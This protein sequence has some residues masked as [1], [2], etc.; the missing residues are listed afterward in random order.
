MTIKTVTLTLLLALSACSN[1]HDYQ[2]PTDSDQWKQDEKFKASIKKLPDEEKKLLTAYLLRA[3]MAEAFG[4]TPPE[5]TIGDAIQNQKDFIEK[6]ALEAEAEKEE[7]TKQAALAAAVEQEH[8]KA[9]A[10]ARAALTVAVVSMEFVPSDAH[11]G[12]YEDGFAITMALQNNTE[13]YMAGV[14][15]AVVFADMFGDNIKSVNLSLDET[16]AAGS[17]LRWSGSLGYN[18][19]KDDDKKLRNTELAKMKISWEPEV[20]LFSDGSRMEIE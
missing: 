4:G 20:Y 12:R 17:T 1:P 5:I 18:Q 13:K 15:G 9:L 11:A 8:Q 10:D 2:V 7:K 14:K 3:G 16:I 19:F 6:K